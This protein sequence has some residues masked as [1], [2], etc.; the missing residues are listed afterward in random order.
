M[1]HSDT[2][3]AAVPLKILRRRG[4]TLP[5]P[6]WPAALNVLVFGLALAACSGPEANDASPSLNP[7]L[8][9]QT[10]TTDRLLIAVDALDE[11]VVWASGTHGT[12]VWTDDGGDTWRSGTVHGADT[13]QFRDVHAVSL[14]EAYL[15]SIGP[16][17]ASRIYHTTDRGRTWDMQ[18]VSETPDAFFDCFALWEDGG[19]VAF[20]DAVGGHFPMI[21]RESASDDWRDVEAP[22]PAQPNEGGFAAS[23]TCVVAPADSL[24]LVGTG[25]AA[26]ARVLRSADRGQTWE[27]AETPVYSG[28]AAGIATLAFRDAEHGVALGGDIAHPDSVTNNSASTADGGR[29][30]H[31]ASPTP[32]RGAVYGS[33]YA[34]G[35]NL[36]VAV[37]PGGAAYS[38]DDAES[39]AV[40]DSLTHWGVDFGSSA[41]GWMVGPE[42]RITK[43]VF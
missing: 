24:V 37:G 41:A 22:P 30:W 7:A 2:T 39:W 21:R 25:N 15:L 4:A 26:R 9:R 6:T 13:L 8:E 32:F 16:G 3:R 1:D 17:V 40:L 20:S 42:G 19:G 35:S 12:F 23:G 34:P 29:T 31:A 28:E 10:S 18:F 36:L 38:L 43:L 11:N 27:A 33:A 5:R 14:D